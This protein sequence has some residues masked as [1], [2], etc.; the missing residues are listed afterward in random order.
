MKSLFFVAF[1]LGLAHPFLDGCGTAMARVGGEIGH[2]GNQN[3]RFDNLFIWMTVRDWIRGEYK[4]PN[5]TGKREV[6][7]SLAVL[8]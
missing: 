6:R 7:A 1:A 8:I 2:N 3:D 4:A 5:S